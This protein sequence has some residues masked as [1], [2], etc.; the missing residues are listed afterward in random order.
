MRVRVKIKINR[1]C[2]WYRIIPVPVIPEWGFLFGGPSCLLNRLPL[3]LDLTHS[4][5]IHSRWLTSYSPTPNRVI[6]RRVVKKV[7]NTGRSQHFFDT[8]LPSIP[9]STKTHHVVQLVPPTRGWAQ[10]K[11]SD[12]VERRSTHPQ[13]MIVECRPRKPL[14]GRWLD[15][16]GR[17]GP[18]DVREETGKR[19]ERLRY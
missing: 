11:G 14:D 17:S 8:D 4:V 19:Q 18:S 9:S 6:E 10:G 16:R 3:S 13:P 15:L 12:Y 5:T 1:L 2:L 7:F